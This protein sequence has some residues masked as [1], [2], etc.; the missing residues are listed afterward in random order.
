MATEPENEARAAIRPVKE[1]VEDALIAQPGV[2]AVD[3]GHKV[4]KGVS[5]GELSIVVYVDK[6]KPKSALPKDQVI[7]VEIDGIKTD[8]KELTIELQPARELA[9]G[10]AFVDATVYP[11]LTGGISMGPVRSIHLDPPDVPTSGQVRSCA[12]GHPGR[13][14]LSPISTWPVSTTRGLRGT[15]WFSRPSRT[16]GVPPCSSAVS[17]VVR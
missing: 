1:R 10:S 8:V 7:P 5:T 12:T 3:I 15:G 14:W 11:T 13:R 17:R 4:S 6:K 16:V 9:D 2:V